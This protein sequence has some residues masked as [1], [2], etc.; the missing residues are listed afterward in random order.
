MKF[1]EHELAYRRAM[2]SQITRREALAKM[3]AG[4]EVSDWRACLETL[5]LALKVPR[6]PSLQRNLI[7]RQRQ[8]GSSSFSCPED[9][10]RSIPLTTSRYLRNM[11]GNVPKV[12]IG[13]L[14]VIPKWGLM[15]SPFGFKQYG[16]SGKWVS[17]IF[18]EVAKCVDDITFRPLDAY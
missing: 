6:I 10:R 14:C 2:Q 15:P 4:L 16:E 11:L 12:S 7:S 9:R 1:L 8:S 13:N 17:D 5:L 3:G 18:P